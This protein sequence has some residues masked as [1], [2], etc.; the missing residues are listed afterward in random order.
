[1]AS[2][3]TYPMKYKQKSIAY[4]INNVIFDGNERKGSDVD[5]QKL[6]KT[7]TALSFDV[8]S[9]RN[10]TREQ[11]VKLLE[12][13]SRDIHKDSD[14]FVCVIL[15]HGEEDKVHGTDGPV[16]VTKLLAPFRGDRCSALAGKPKLF[17]IQACRGTQYDDGADALGVKGDGPGGEDEDMGVEDELVTYRIPREA[18]FLIAYSSVRGYRAWRHEGKGSWFIQTLC[19]VLEEHREKLD[20]LTMMTRVNHTVAF[21]FPSQGRAH[22]KKQ[23]PC[24]TS[25]LTKDLFFRKT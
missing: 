15:S 21:D 2:S 24:I 6:I 5:E 8:K 4:I 12:K 20:L 16:E 11:M 3:H 13:V 19:K 10:Q 7:F 9:V 22:K 17:F 23:I 1:M 18:D 14:C 25:M